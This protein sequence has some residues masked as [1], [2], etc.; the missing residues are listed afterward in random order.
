VPPLAAFDAFVK[1]WSVRYE[2]GGVESLTKDRALLA[3]YFRLSTGSICARQTSSKA[4]SRRSATAPAIQ[5]MSLEQDCARHNLEE[6]VPELAVED[7]CDSILPRLAGL[8]QSCAVLR[9][10]DDTALDT[11]SA[12]CRCAGTPGVR[13]RTWDSPR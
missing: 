12:C 5:G 3:F 11:N 2:K 1:T 10:E 6:L 9:E 8:D 7:F 4:R 13:S